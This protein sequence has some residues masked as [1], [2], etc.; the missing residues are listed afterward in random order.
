MGRPVRAQK[1]GKGSPTYRTP[2]R[3]FMPVLAYRGTDG[4]VVDIIKDPAR[5]SPL[6]EIRYADSARGYIVAIEGMKVGDTLSSRIKMLQELAE[7]SQI[8]CIETWPNSGPKLCRA[9][10]SFA[11]LVSKTASHGIVQLPSKKTI[12]LSLGCKASIGIPAGEGRGEKPFLKAGSKYHL[13]CARNKLYPR[14]S[15]VAMNAVDHPYGGSGTGK[16]RP[17]VSRHAPPG[18]KVGAISPR[19]TGKSKK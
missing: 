6:A 19:R 7:G 4:M 1:R 18:A 13:M 12:K 11:T 3:K 2:P 5:N 10:G 9:P 15:G 16:K 14:T 17:P 8:S